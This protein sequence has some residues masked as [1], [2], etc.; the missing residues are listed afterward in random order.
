MSLTTVDATLRSGTTQF[1]L[2]WVQELS[3][4][5]TQRGLVQQHTNYQAHLHDVIKQRSDKR[6][7][8]EERVYNKWITQDKTFS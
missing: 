1:V 8:R 4:P 2:V 6:K 7:D 3:D 5:V